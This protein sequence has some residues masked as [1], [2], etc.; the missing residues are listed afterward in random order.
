MGRRRPSAIGAA[1]VATNRL[2]D[3]VDAEL[4]LPEDREEW[5]EEDYEEER[6]AIGRKLIMIS[7]RMARLRDRLRNTVHQRDHFRGIALHGARMGAPQRRKSALTSNIAIEAAPGTQ[8]VVIP[9]EGGVYLVAEAS[10]G[11]LQG[12]G[13]EK[14]AKALQHS[15][16]QNLLSGPNG[17]RSHWT[18]KL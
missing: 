2:F 1:I 13:A 16:Q 15:A 9:L 3:S 5:D 10:H 14:V 6:D 12:A 7:G 8:A 4:D 18:E 11:M 17:S